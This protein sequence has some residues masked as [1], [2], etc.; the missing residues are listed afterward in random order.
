MGRIVRRKRFDLLLD[1]CALLD[2][3]PP[4]TGI[5]IGGDVPELKHLKAARL[6]LTERMVVP[7]RLERPQVTQA[8]QPM[9]SNIV[10][11]PRPPSPSASSCWRPGERGPR[12]LPRRSVESQSWWKAVAQ[13]AADQSTFRPSPTR[14]SCYKTLSSQPRWGRLVV[15]VPSTSIGRRS[16]G[17]A[18]GDTSW[19]RPADQ[20]PLLRDDRFRNAHRDVVNGHP[21]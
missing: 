3:L 6:G 12:S 20:K 21:S 5:A 4:T 2:V 7:G 9:R 14:S 17:P 10:A 8:I 16:L 13:G 11:P 19:R 18:S 15:P 1:A